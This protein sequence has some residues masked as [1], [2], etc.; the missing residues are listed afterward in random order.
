MQVD[1]SFEEYSLERA[2]EAGADVL[3]VAT[4]FREGLYRRLR[5]EAEVPPRTHDWRLFDAPRQSTSFFLLAA[6]PLVCSRAQN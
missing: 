2:A 3:F 4:G 6:M 5:D 1:V